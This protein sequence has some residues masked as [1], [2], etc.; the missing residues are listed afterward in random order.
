MD[1]SL[2]F[3]II[4][5]VIFIVLAV[6]IKLSLVKFNKQF[7]SKLN[8]NQE[9]INDLFSFSYDIYFKAPPDTIVIENPY[10]CTPIDL[11]PC[12]I[13]DPFS[14]IGCKS[15]IATCLH[16]E[17][18][19]PYIDFNGVEHTI[20]ANVDINDGYCLT[21]NNPSQACNPYHGDLVLI[22]TDPD[23]L[24]SMLY[25]KCKNP[26]YIGKSEID[27]ACD[28]VF[29]CNGKIDDINQPLLEIK[30]ECENG[31]VSQLINDVPSCTTPSVK[32]Y[33]EF[34]ND[35][36]FEGVETVDS[37]RFVDDISSIG[38]YPGA[39]LMN[40]CKYCLLTGK[41]IPN[42]EMVPT[43]DDGWQ[44]VL[45]NSK[46]GGLPIRRNKTNRVL[47]GISGPD[48]IINLNILE[49]YVHGYLNETKFEQMTAIFSTHDNIDM[50]KY[51]GVPTNGLFTYL[52]LQPHQLVFPESFGSM[53]FINYPGVMC[54]GPQVWGVLWDDLVYHCDFTNE[55]P[56]DRNP[57]DHKSYK[58]YYKSNIIFATGPKCP[59]KHHSLM[60]SGAFRNWDKYEGFN[61]AHFP[62]VVNRLVKYEIT[63]DFKSSTDIKYIMS[64]FN[65]STGESV[66]YG[67][68]NSDIYDQW[69]AI[70]IPK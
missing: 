37:D 22:Q 42:G 5:S 31:T 53:S 35:F 54:T 23:S 67:S 51:M 36:Y 70:T 39:K 32:E 46:G 2:L 50:L 11:Q 3:F 24:E 40:P 6:I 17:K 15:L 34:D 4:L 18:D 56:W 25:C 8:K 14:C 44:C 57:K 19:T 27:G 59:A 28:D 38:R 49:L 30:C 13:N 16:F 20:P 55:V 64:T 29:I 26:G 60:S 43:E 33:T 69:F 58:S 12:K 62:T 63:Q 7:Q 66:H 52:D 41:Y 65:F 1:K 21:Q 9:A 10:N 45:L 68:N 48:A 47:K 61:S